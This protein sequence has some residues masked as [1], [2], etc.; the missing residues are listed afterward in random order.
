MRKKEKYLQSGIYNI[1]CLT[2]NKTNDGQTGGNLNLRYFE[3]IRYIRNNNPHS[4]YS[5]LIL[6]HEHQFGTIRT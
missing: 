5:M 1:K 4:A 2:F 6:K 3:H